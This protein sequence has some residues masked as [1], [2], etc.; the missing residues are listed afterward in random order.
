MERKERKHCNM[1]QMAS[2]F[3]LF[4]R[5][6]SLINSVIHVI[7][8]AGALAFG[9]PQLWWL[10]ASIWFARYIFLIPSFLGKLS[11]VVGYANTITVI[12]LAILVGLLLASPTLSNSVLFSGFLLVVVLDG[13][14]GWLA[15]RYDQSSVVGE[16]MDMEVDAFMVLALSWLHFEAGNAEWWILIPGGMRYYVEIFLHRFLAGGEEL[17]PKKLRASVA[18]MF[19]ISLVGAFVLNEYWRELTLKISSIL[20]MCSFSMSI[21]LRVVRR[22]K[23]I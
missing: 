15:R 22:L 3:N 8:L 13:V 5:R 9:L 2:R 23:L 6:W 16:V 12:R 1:S 17:V 11:W 20:I 14:D 21:L 10:V 18:V 19:F 4:L 7:G